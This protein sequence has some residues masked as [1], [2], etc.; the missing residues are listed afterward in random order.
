MK[1]IAGRVKKTYYILLKLKQNLTETKIED[2]S[3]FI[4]VAVSESLLHLKI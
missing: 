4:L 3:N 2:S 1:L